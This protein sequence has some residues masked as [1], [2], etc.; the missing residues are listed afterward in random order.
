MCASVLIKYRVEISI[1][2]DTFP[3]VHRLAVDGSYFPLSPRRK[4]TMTGE[5]VSYSGPGPGE[6]NLIEPPAENDVEEG[7]DNHSVSSPSSPRR[8]PFQPYVDVDQLGRITG[9]AVLDS[10]GRSSLGRKSNRGSFMGVRRRSHLHNKTA[11]EVERIVQTG[12]VR[13]LKNCIRSHQ[14]LPFDCVRSR[15]WQVYILLNNR[16]LPNY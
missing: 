8:C 2:D 15:L 1:L 5:V 12:K 3:R 7:K 14:W 9:T 13:E 16:N 4:Y 6:S 10:P 11:D